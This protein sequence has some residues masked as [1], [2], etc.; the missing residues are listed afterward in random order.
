[1]NEKESNTTDGGNWKSILFGPEWAKKN[2]KSNNN[3]VDN[4]EDQTKKI[5][6]KSLWKSVLFK[7]K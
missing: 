1:M 2:C 3:R 7:N 4:E 6:K 5:D